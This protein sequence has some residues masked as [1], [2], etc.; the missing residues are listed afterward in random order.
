MRIALYAR[1]SKADLNLDNQ[2]I[3]LREYA[4]KM[5]WQTKEFIE[6]ES[7]RKSRPVQWELYQRL[8]RKEFDGLLIYKLD[9]WGRSLQEIVTHVNEFLMKGVTFYS[10]RE[11]LDFSTAGGRLM[12]HIMSSFAEFERDIIRERTMAGLDRAKSW[13]RISGRHPAGCGCGWTD[14]K[15]KHDG[16]VKPVRDASN[17]VVGWRCG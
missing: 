5:G 1:V 15:I 2:L 8:C 10:L 14:G 13:G 16:L 11:N 7:T 4:S 6:K 12:F 9:R 3:P 17:K